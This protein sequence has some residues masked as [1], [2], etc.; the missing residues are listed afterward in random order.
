MATTKLKIS[1]KKD[2]DAVMVRIDA[3]MKKGEKSLTNK[4]AQDLK[5]MASAA[6]DYEKRIYVIS[7][8]KTIEG[9]VEL[10]MY[11]RKL[12]QKDLARVMG[13][14][15]AK[16]SQILNGKR[17]PDVAFLKAAHQK[18]GIDAEFLLT[19]V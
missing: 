8:P 11:E 15:E 14:G 9:M 12:K 2:Y 1:T 16:I 4:E 7:A 6:R 13:L 3:L 19:H 18:L 10:K 17:A 5:V